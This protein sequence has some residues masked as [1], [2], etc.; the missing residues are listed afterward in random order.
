MLYIFF[1]HNTNNYM[2]HFLALHFAVNVGKMSDKV[3]D[4][5]RPTSQNMH[6]YSTHQPVVSGSSSVGPS[7]SSFPESSLEVSS[8]TP[9]S[10]S[11]TPRP[12]PRFPVAPLM[13]VVN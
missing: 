5:S 12:K 1:N 10:V 13:Y 9:S 11:F 3:Q 4:E 7:H 8:S 2:S 6:L